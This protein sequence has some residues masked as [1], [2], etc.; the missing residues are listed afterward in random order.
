MRIRQ[1]CSPVNLQQEM[2]QTVAWPELV[3]VLG[4][5]WGGGRNDTKKKQ[6]AQRGA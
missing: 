4:E 6:T 2:Q 3:L 5:G 1:T